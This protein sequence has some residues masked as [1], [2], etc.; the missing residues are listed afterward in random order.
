MP[1]CPE[2]EAD[3]EVEEASLSAGE[4]LVCPGCGVEIEIRETDPLELDVLP[5][6]DE[7]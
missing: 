6:E 3:L 5:E 4:M 7:A 1:S 2:C